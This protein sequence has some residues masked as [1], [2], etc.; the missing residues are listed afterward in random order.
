MGR[1][2]GGAGGTNRG[3]ATAHGTRRRERME[4]MER[5]ERGRVGN[6]PYGTTEARRGG[7][8]ETIPG[9]FRETQNFA[10]LQAGGGWCG[11]LNEC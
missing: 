3:G 8:R 5:M 1:R 10:S 6:P 11:M 4:Q 7:L 2:A 9:G